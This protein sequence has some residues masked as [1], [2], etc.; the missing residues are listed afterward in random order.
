MPYIY[1]SN[2]RQGQ[3]FDDPEDIAIRIIY[4]TTAD[5]SED[6]PSDLC[7][8]IESEIAA[9]AP[10]KSITID[11]VTVTYQRASK[12]Y[13]ASVL[14]RDRRCRDGETYRCFTNRAEFD[15]YMKNNAHKLLDNVATTVWQMSRGHG[16][17]TQE[18]TI[19]TLR[20]AEWVH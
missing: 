3:I 18:E 1:T 20:S 12:V 5:T 6:W 2:L 16:T 11:G 8:E 7:A 19:D 9:L 10:G 17:Y 13:C 15:R 4:D 14:V